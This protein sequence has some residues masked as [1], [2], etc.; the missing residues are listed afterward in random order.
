MHWI[1]SEHCIEA[2][3]TKFGIGSQAWHWMPTLGM[4]TT[5]TCECRHTYFFELK[6]LRYQSQMVPWIP[7]ELTLRWI[8]IQSL[9]LN[10]R[11]AI[12]CQDWDWISHNLV[13]VVMHWIQRLGLNPWF[14]IQLSTFSSRHLDSDWIPNMHAIIAGSFW[15][16]AGVFVEV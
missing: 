16:C 10:P 11:L 3:N 15:N 14:N 6:W 13:N 8:P 4:N 5:Y 1:P 12:E 2:L 7:I 9:G